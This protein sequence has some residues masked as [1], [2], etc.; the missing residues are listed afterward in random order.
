METPEAELL[1][2]DG[3]RSEK[4]YTNK[5][6][7]TTHT[8]TCL[9]CMHLTIIYNLLIATSVPEDDTQ[10]ELMKALAVSATPPFAR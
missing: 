10:V 9:A 4:N 3:T 8:H 2:P 6:K 5:E 7:C 1:R